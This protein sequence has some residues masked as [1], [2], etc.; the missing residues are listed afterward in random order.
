M[1]NC[2]FIGSETLQSIDNEFICMLFR[3]DVACEQLNELELSTL[4]RI[5][6]L[7]YA[8]QSLSHHVSMLPSILSSLIDTID[9]PQIDF[10]T[11]V[12]DLCEEPNVA[13][14]ILKIANSDMYNKKG[15]RDVTTISHATSMIGLVSVAYIAANV[16]MSHVTRTKSSFF[17]HFSELIQ[18]H[19]LQTAMVCRDLAHQHGVNSFS[20]H[21]LGLINIVGTVYCF[22][23]LSGELGK[24]KLEGHPNP[25][26]Y[27]QVCRE[28]AGTITIEIAKEW[29]LPRSIVTALEQC[30]DPDCEQM[31]ELAQMLSLADLTSKVSLLI[32]QGKLDRDTGIKLLVDKNIPFDYI[33]NFLAM[34]TSL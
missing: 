22:N 4:K 13:C 6:E 34:S 30:N 29:S 26:L 10:V 19:A 21:I 2:Y 12:T 27:K 8:P 9:N 1:F 15:K 17:S 24:I 14:E 5:E 25:E 33:E 31:D 7:L 11:V 3:H 18:K 28:W 32:A 20:C 23:C 16:L